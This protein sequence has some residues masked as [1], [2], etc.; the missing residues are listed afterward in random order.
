MAPLAAGLLAQG[1]ALLLLAFVVASSQAAT[2]DEVANLIG[3]FENDF[4]A[5]TT[6][7]SLEQLDENDGMAL[8]GTGGTGVHGTGGTGGAVVGVSNPVSF[9]HDAN[10][11]LDGSDPGFVTARDGSAQMR[12]PAMQMY[13]GTGV[14]IQN[15]LPC[16]RERRGTFYFWRAED[17]GG[18][19]INDQIMLCRRFDATFLLFFVFFL[20]A[21]P[22]CQCKLCV[23]CAALLFCSHFVNSTLSG[24]TLISACHWLLVPTLQGGS[25]KSTNGR[26]CKLSLIHKMARTRTEGHAGKRLLTLTAS[27]DGILRTHNYT[28]VYTKIEI[29]EITI[30]TESICPNDWKYGGRTSL[31][32]TKNCCTLVDGL[33]SH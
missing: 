19:S 32:T 3:A 17:S 21:L 27:H 8:H 25:A 2:A 1:I 10:L 29:N 24:P 12:I 22:L 15:D 18:S 6:L 5:S 14:H 23:Y 7:D 9:S 16:T 20:F 33:L 31:C 4:V 26:H 30:Y 28:Y 13:T 11:K